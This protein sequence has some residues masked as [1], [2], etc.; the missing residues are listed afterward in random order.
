METVDVTWDFKL[1]IPN[2]PDHIKVKIRAGESIR[3][4]ITQCS[5]FVKNAEKW[6]VAGINIDESRIGTDCTLGKRSGNT[7]GLINDDGWI[8]K[9]GLNGSISGRWPAN[10]ILDE[11][12]AEILDEQTG[13]LNPPGN[14]N[15]STGNEIF[16]SKVNTINQPGVNCYPGEYGK[17]ASRFFYCAKASSSERNRGLEG[18]PFIEKSNGNKW[19]DQDY[20]VSSGERHLSA[21]SGPRQ[22]FH[23]TVKPIAL[24]KYILKLL[25]PPGSP[26]CLDPFCGSGSTLVA[27]KEL[28]INCIGIE[29]E[30]EYVE[31]ARTRID[32]VKVEKQLDF[33][34]DS[35]IVNSEQTKLA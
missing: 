20:R 8:P 16:G 35:A 13:I 23:P 27:A 26:T 11:E 4:R 15:R 5:G 24:M 3:L 31:I 17:G 29:K 1:H 32:N 2:I 28:G 21:Q 22:N 34:I 18:M 12:A 10:L 7:F 9:P 6:G 19:T 33:F 25:A 30:A 14:K